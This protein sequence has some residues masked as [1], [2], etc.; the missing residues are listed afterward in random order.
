VLADPNVPGRIY[1]VANDDPDNNV[2]TGDA[3]NVFI[4][5]S[6]DNGTCSYRK[7][8]PHVVRPASTSSDVTQLGS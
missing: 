6:T 8:R 2:T 1:V 3:A 7:L 5:R 4:V